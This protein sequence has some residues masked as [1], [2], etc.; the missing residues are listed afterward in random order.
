SWALRPELLQGSER[1][2]ELARKGHATPGRRPNVVII[3]TDDQTASEMR[4]MPK[5]RALLGGAGARFSDSLS[6]HPLCCPARAMML[7]GQFAQNNG[8]RSNYWP[9]GGYYALESENTLPVWLKD[10][11]Y[12]TAFVGKYLNEYGELNPLEVPRGWDHWIGLVRRTYDFYN[13]VTNENG[14]L[15]QQPGTYQTDYYGDQSVRLVR[16][17]AARDKPFFLWESHLAP[18]T[19]CPSLSDS[20]GPGCWGPPTPSTAYHGWYDDV[21]MP[22][23]RDPSFNEAN[24][25]DKPPS[26]TKK[27]RYSATQRGSLTEMFQRRIESLQSVD[28]AVARTVDALED[29]GELDDTLIIFTSDN[30][31]LLGEHRLSGKVVPY[32]PS[33]RVPLLMRGPSVPAGVRRSAT[34]G[35]VDLAPTVLAATGA[36][37]SV[38]TDGRNLLPVLKGEKQG[39]ETMLIQGGPRYRTS[40]PEWEYRGVRT[41]RYTYVE[42]RRTGFIEL[43][44]RLRDPYQL[45]NVAGEPAYAATQDELRRRLLKLQTCAGAD[46]RRTFGD[47]PAPGSQP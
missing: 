36:S 25:G 6:P 42:R 44:D 21:P 32:E 24:V 12:Q 13:F 37:A 34:V 20:V 17:M 4:W 23:Q 28:D 35:T 7:T 10:S 22:Q 26:I 39:W 14:T 18:H 15:Q 47:V 30:G 40:G 16:K 46:C 3:T 9:Y 19:A 33:L 27:G 38:P 31:Y 41:E 5:T 45:R 29:A 2:Q 1:F 8:V 11:G 43:Y